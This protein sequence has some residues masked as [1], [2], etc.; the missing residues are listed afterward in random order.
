MGT[1][2]LRNVSEASFE[3]VLTDLES[4]ADGWGHDT[5]NVSREDTETLRRR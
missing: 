1:L 5:S 3:A 4:M 2:T